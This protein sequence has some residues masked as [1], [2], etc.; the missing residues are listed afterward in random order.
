MRACRSGSIEVADAKLLTAVDQPLVDWRERAVVLGLRRSRST[1]S[2]SS[3]ATGVIRINAESYG[4]WRLVEP[5]I[6]PAEGAKVESLL[7][8]L[9]SLRVTDGPKGFVAD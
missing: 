2:R 3:E 1:R 4:R 8:A 5:V 9:S 6:A 7:A